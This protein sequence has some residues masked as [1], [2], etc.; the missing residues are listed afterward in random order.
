MNVEQSE[1]QKNIEEKYEMYNQQMFNKILDLSSK[2]R[3]NCQSKSSLK[4]PQ[5]KTDITMETVKANA[6]RKVQIQRCSSMNTEDTDKILNTTLK[7]KRD[8]FRSRLMNLNIK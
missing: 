8:E 2:V 6:N 7:V 5:L 1:N 3:T 4:S